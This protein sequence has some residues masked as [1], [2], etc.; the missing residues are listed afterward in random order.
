M[1]LCW[2]RAWGCVQPSV[3][4]LLDSVCFV[5]VKRVFCSLREFTQDR[6]HSLRPW[7]TPLR[8]SWPFS[9]GDLLAD[10]IV[11][12][13]DWLPPFCIR[14][15]IG[16]DVMY[17]VMI[18]VVSCSWGLSKSWSA[19]KFCGKVIVILIVCL[20]T[21]FT[22]HGM[23]GQTSRDKSHLSSLNSFTGLDSLGLRYRTF[24]EEPELIVIL[25]YVCV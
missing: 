18:Y 11:W 1:G 20:I 21:G 15:F 5:A 8:S 6:I 25:L 2:R 17:I 4:K 13:T 23:N 19:L 7:T 10:W 9:A 24:L 14:Y 12:L 16:F 3:P 22:L